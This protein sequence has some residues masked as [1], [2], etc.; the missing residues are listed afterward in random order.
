[1]QQ[2][3]AMLSRTAR[4]RH[5]RNQFGAGRFA[6]WVLL[7]ATFMAY[8]S[9]V[10]SPFGWHFVPRDP[11]EMWR[12]F[13]ATPF[14]DN[15]SDQRPDWIANLL[16]AI[17]LGFLASGT[18]ASSRG[19]V[20]RVLGTMVALL[21]SIAFVLAL[22]YG[23]LFFPPRTVS[24]NYIIA[25][26]IGVCAG[27]ALFHLSRPWWIDRHA[28]TN[29]LVRLKLLL[30]GAIVAI[31]V[32][33]LF[34]FD[35]VLSVDDLHQRIVGLPEVLRTLP[36]VGRPEAIRLL[37]TAGTAALTVPIGM[38]LALRRDRPGLARIAV[39]G[40]GWMA[41]LLLATMLILS[42]TPSLATL[43][44]RVAGIVAGAAM[45]QWLTRQDLIR[46]RFMLARLMPLLLAVYLP[47]VVIAQGLLKLHWQ[48]PDQALAGINLRGL[49]PFFYYYIVSKAHALQSIAAHAAM[50]APVGVM[51]W[52]R[53]GGTRSTA[54]VAGVMAALL[55]SA[56]EIG[57]AL[58][59][60]VQPDIN[61]VIVA[62]LA[63]VL[64][65]R[66]MPTVWRTLRAL[67]AE[68]SPADRGAMNRSAPTMRTSELAAAQIAA[69]QR[70]LE[71][72]RLVAAP[73][74]IPLPARLP[75][76]ILCAVGAGALA[77]FYPLG[78]WIAGAALLA[79]AAV[80]W[81]RPALWFALLP[82]V[83]P[84]LDLAPWTGWLVTTEADIAVLATLAV[85]LLRD[86]P[87][88]SDLS[89]R[90]PARIV[91]AFAVVACAVG[92]A[93]G[94]TAPF[95]IPGGTGNPYLQPL[96]ALH[97]AKPFVEALA[98]LP[99][100]QARQRVHGDVVARIGAG[101]LAGLVAVGLAAAVERVA[102][103]G[104]LDVQSDYRVVATF[105]SMH[106]G[107]GHIGA[108]VA[109]A[110]P[111]IAVCLH[112]VRAWKLFALII[113]ALIGGYAL[114][115]TFARTA[116]VAAF[117]AMLTATCGWV[118]AQRRRGR[119]ASA[120]AGLLIGC[121]AIIAVAIGFS[122]P[123]MDMRLGEVIP[124][125]ATR[126]TN[127]ANG[128][129]VQGNGVTNLLLGMGTGTFPRIAALR[130]PPDARPGSYTVVHDGSHSFL[131]AEFG[132]A[133]YFGQKVPVSAGASY[134][135]GLDLRVLEP[136]VGLGV[137]LCSKL[138]LYST[139][140][141][142]VRFQPGA[143]EGW[144][145]VSAT[146][147]AP[148]RRGPLP[149][150][151]EL[152]LSTGTDDPVEI[153][154]VELIGP[155]GRNLVANGDFAN[156]TARWYFTSDRHT[157]WRIFNLALATWFDGGL[158][159]VA[160]LVLLLSAAMAGAGRAVSRGDPLGAPVLGALVAILTSGVFDDVLEAPRLALLYYIV[161]ILGMLLGWPANPDAPARP[162]QQ[163]RTISA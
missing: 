41:A 36:G 26:S 82:A 22:K 128:L 68:H 51:V 8:G 11:A 124:D 53:H 133:F 39:I 35:L 122:T 16:M 61:A 12:L 81:W 103:V 42:A 3:P 144:Q 6:L 87:S 72:Q 98:L 162:A 44:C 58:Q 154:N 132:P 129:A 108:F 130:F 112:R 138:L 125:F 117:G 50:Y 29:D 110:M 121:V 88:W 89:P 74:V 93:R 59:P 95:A 105:S 114:V 106:V 109:F 79:W 100:L 101:I 139:G 84:S 52:L 153:A 80:L 78:G 17:P 4:Q 27:V 145:H 14:F 86:P 21:I 120:A 30:D 107:G 5:Q 142:T 92:V 18:L 60:G 45:L 137:G 54:W 90:G 85:L 40:L 150:P 31:V 116:Y 143:R 141:Q 135:L 151:A 55:A 156:D 119:A 102:F 76:A 10:L 73:D 134:S 33:A 123:Y 126:K 62:A 136:D 91:L 20:L 38:R 83:V 7:Y 65:N 113:A 19:A 47:L 43:A 157:V 2:S 97:L 149:V 115:V 75:L 66:A 146:L 161:V 111:F 147:R 63:A 159:G 158:F 1:M 48:T 34:P 118:V 49:L 160:A 57:R 155:D 70:S 94:L 28:E 104:L 64:T 15:A 71:P 131:R 46:G 23:Q 163:G 13:L 9:L 96:N 69:L 24:L 37:L 25:Q 140:C 152:S 32:F 56:V 148:L 99:F 77:A 67:A 127:W